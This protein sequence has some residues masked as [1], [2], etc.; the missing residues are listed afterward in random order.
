MRKNTGKSLSKNI[1]AKF[2]QKR[3]DYTKQSTTEAIKITQKE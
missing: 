2:W 1:S 3:L